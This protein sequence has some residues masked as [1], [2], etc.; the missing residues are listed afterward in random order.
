[1]AEPDRIVFRH[2]EVVEALL[3][4]EGIK[5]GIWGLFIRFG[6]GGINVGPTRDELNPA[7]VVPVLEIGLQKF[8]EVNNMSVDAATLSVSISKPS[9][10]KRSQSKKPAG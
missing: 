8:E 10:A 9:K 5:Q 7:A 1:M 2:K 3:R 6:I 4:R